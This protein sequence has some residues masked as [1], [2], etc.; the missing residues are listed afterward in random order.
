MP[1]ATGQ[2]IV[3][4]LN[5]NPN[6][7]QQEQNTKSKEDGCKKAD[8]QLLEDDRLLGG[9]TALRARHLKHKEPGR[10]E[11]SDGQQN[12]GQVWEHGRIDG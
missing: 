5:I 10:E 9:G 4:L 3:L 2:H 11:C 8:Q 7:Q 6:R 12:G 1:A